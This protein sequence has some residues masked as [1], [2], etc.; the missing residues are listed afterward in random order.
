MLAGVFRNTVPAKT[1]I[2]F[3]GG[4][5]SPIL[6]DGQPPPG[7]SRGRRTIDLGLRRDDVSGGF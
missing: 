1:G 2:H 6:H 4:K 5:R 3:P 7:T